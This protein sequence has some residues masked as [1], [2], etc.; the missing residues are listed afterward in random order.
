MKREKGSS[1]SSFDNKRF[2]SA[3]AEAR[4]HDSVK[5]ML[6]LKERGFGIDSSHLVYFETI[7]T[8]RG[9]QEF[10]KPPK[11]AAITRTLLRTQSQ[12]LQSERGRLDMIQ[13]QLIPS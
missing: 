7:I 6:G 11:T 9:W 3:D 4:F 5:G 13:G 2:V 1:S 8:R 10:C 12:S